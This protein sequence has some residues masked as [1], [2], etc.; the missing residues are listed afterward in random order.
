MFTFEKL[1]LINGL[2]IENPENAVQNSYAWCMAELGDYIYVG[3]ARNLISSASMAWGNGGNE[4]STPSALVTGDDNAAEIWR[5]KKES[6]TCIWKRVFKTKASEN[7]SGFRAMVMHDNGK[8]CALYAAG[9]GPK[10]SLFKSTD[11]LHWRRIDTSNL[12]GTNSRSLVSFRG[13]LYMATLDETLEGNVPYLYS[14]YDPEV[15]PFKSVIDMN[16]PNF[17][18]C[19]NPVGGID[20]LRVFNNKLYVSIGTE[21]GAEVWRSNDNHPKTNNWTIVA[22]KGFGD[23]LNSSIMSS[24]IF[25]DHLYVAVTKKVP[26]ALMAPLGFDLIRIDKDDNWS[27]IVGGKPILPSE[28]LTGCRNN[29][30]SGFNSGFNNYFNVYGWQ[31]TSF[32]DNLVL[33]TCDF[34]TNIIT[35]IVGLISMK[36]SNIAKWG[37]KN[38]YALLNCYLKILSIIQ[39]YKY[40][41][42]FDMYTS[43]DGCHFRPVNLD[44][45]N[46]P[47]NYSGRTLLVTSEDDLYLGTANPFE[48]LEVWK[49]DYENSCDNCA[50]ENCIINYFS[51]MNKMNKELIKIYPKLLELLPKTFS[52]MVK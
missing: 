30:L 9:V 42:G 46:N 31:I 34:S 4:N 24:G 23:S 1:N 12:S 33:T 6:G 21:N 47:T 27:V 19:K 36:D 40:P 14:S 22:D 16:N 13:K 39:K 50:N 26:F 49:V 15:K 41:M 5:Y 18:S 37:C 17:E 38:Y 8:E 25:K 51:K 52:S 35:I 28:P 20:D 32:K 44:G 10:L 2:D 11:G 48:G 3:T 43:K 7:I 29:P 45:L